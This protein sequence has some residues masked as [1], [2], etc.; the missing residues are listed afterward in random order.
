MDDVPGLEHRVAVMSVA[1]YL[2]G[3]VLP[4]RKGTVDLD[5]LIVRVVLDNGEVLLQTEL[6]TAYIIYGY[7]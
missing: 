3:V 4:E 6:V 1:Q 2:L 5:G 7:T